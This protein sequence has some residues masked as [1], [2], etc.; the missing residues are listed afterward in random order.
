MRKL[1]V[2]EWMSLDG[3][4]DSASME[5][6]F[7]PYHSESRAKSIQETIQRCDIM[8]YGRKTYQMLA[9]YWSSFK[10]NEMGVAEKLN[11]GRKYVVSTTL[12]EASWENTTILH[13]NFIEE[14]VRLKDEGNGDILVQ[15]SATLVK[16]L[17]DADLVDEFKFLIQPYLMGTGSG[18]FFLGMTKGLEFMDL[19]Q[20]ESGV[21]ELHYKPSKK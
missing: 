21:L 6:W 10:D 15:G 8:L 4:F 7:N 1:I 5:Q 17:L 16:S 13:A 14:I 11:K 18:Q 2:N 12:V 20:L 9:P 19:K 3:V